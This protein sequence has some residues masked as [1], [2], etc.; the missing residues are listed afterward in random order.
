M[1]VLL[2]SCLQLLSRAGGGQASPPRAK[3]RRGEA[4]DSTSSF[5]V[6]CPKRMSSVG[7]TFGQTESECS[8]AQQDSREGLFY[9]IYLHDSCFVTLEQQLG[10]PTGRFLEHGGDHKELS[11]R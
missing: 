6:C 3:T 1:L 10:E 8:R 9:H 11:A 5:K 7:V 4:D 2:C